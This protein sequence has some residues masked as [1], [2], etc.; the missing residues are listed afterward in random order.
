MIVFIA[1]IY[2]RK[3]C[4]LLIFQLFI[5]LDSFRLEAMMIT[6]MVFGIIGL[7]LSLL[8]LALIWICHKR[9]SQSAPL[10]ELQ[11][12]DLTA[13]TQAQHLLAPDAQG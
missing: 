12:K 5:D 4:E 3:P 10:E 8:S 6:A 9:G 11:M 2:L 1:V 13:K 7:L